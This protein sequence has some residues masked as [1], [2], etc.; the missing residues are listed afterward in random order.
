MSI[1][2]AGPWSY[3][4][5]TSFNRIQIEQYTEHLQYIVTHTA[6]LLL[7]FYSMLLYYVVSCY[8]WVLYGCSSRSFICFV[9][10]VPGPGPVR[11]PWLGPGRAGPAGP[12]AWHR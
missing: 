6:F 7:M 10:S 9:F 8:I 12:A 1:Q 11:G 3:T 5:T 2:T 4:K